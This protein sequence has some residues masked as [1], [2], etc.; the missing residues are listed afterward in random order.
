VHQDSVGDTAE[1][2]APEAAPAAGPESA[3][4]AAASAPAATESK[5]DPTGLLD[6]GDA[7]PEAPA[8]DAPAADTV[9]EYKL[10]VPEGAKFTDET[11][12][13]IAAFAKQHK[14]S[15]E[16]AQ[17]LVDTYAETLADADKRATESVQATFAGW[18]KEIREHKDFG[19][20]PEKIRQT[21]AHFAR[22]ID[23]VAP[24]YRQS[25]RDAGAMLEPALYLAFAKFGKDMSAPS[26]TVKGDGAPAAEPDY[27]ASF[28]NT[29]KRYGGSKKDA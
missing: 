14:L 21:S 3:A 27:A 25:L 15:A 2:L 26:G 16:T 12:P 28:P 24:G 23:H 7:A 9:S 11:V 20:S 29:P 8:A 1:L 17:A 19:G 18:A 10:N 4:P 5:P 13:K 22:A 6:G